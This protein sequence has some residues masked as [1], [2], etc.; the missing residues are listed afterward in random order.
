MIFFI[1]FPYLSWLLRRF[2]FS[3]FLIRA[4]PMAG[5][6]QKRIVS[7]SCNMSLVVRSHQKIWVISTNH[8][9]YV[10]EELREKHQKTIWRFPRICVPVGIPPWLWVSPH[11]GPWCVVFFVAGRHNIG[12]K[13]FATLSLSG[14]D[15]KEKIF[16]SAGDPTTGVGSAPARGSTSGLDMA[17]SQGW[18]MTFWLVV[19]LP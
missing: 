4:L 11:S 19:Y 12:L 10:W 6:C 7:D 15:D 17:R 2:P 16:F 9:K 1:I 18:N 3:I 8:L 14:N 13:T 5:Q